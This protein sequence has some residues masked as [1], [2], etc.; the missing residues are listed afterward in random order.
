MKTLVHM[1]IV[2]ERRKGDSGDE[3]DDGIGSLS[4][5][6]DDNNLNLLEDGAESAV[7]LSARDGGRD[8]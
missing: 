6:T 8:K 4:E 2:Q 5:L 3:M 7:T 1:A